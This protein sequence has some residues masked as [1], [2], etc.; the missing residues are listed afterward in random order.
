MGE[1]RPHCLDIDVALASISDSVGFYAVPAA[2]NPGFLHEVSEGSSR[3]DINFQKMKTT[4]T[5]TTTRTTEPG[6]HYCGNEQCSADRRAEGW[7]SHSP[8]NCNKCKGNWCA[9]ESQS[10]N[11]SISERDRNQPST[12]CTN[13][14][15]DP[16]TSGSLVDCCSPLEL[17]L[18]AHGTDRSNLFFLCL[19]S[20]P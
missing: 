16:Y 20:C 3:V 8:D 2:Q 15:N 19:S 9:Y 5:S 6:T 13:E 18:G 4:L 14:G 17:C 10:V 12:S 11:V 1:T 7:C